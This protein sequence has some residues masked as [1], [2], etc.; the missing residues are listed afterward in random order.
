M[1]PRV[2][3]VIPLPDLL[4]DLEFADGRRARFDIAPY[5]H[6]PV[7]ARLRDP[8]YFSRAVVSHGTVQW[9]G[10]IDFDPDTLYL[11]SKNI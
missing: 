6:A 1:N 5:V 4:L 3:V 11:D 2:C 9:P 7:F 10:G 8:K